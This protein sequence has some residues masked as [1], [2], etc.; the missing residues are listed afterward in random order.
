MAV[1]DVGALVTGGL[2]AGEMERGRGHHGHDASEAHGPCANCGTELIGPHCVEC[3]QPA[4]IHR[5]MMGLLHDIL[6]G[7]FH[8]EGKT[9]ATLPMLAL[10]P[11]HLTRRYIAGERVKFVSPMALFLFSVFLM[12]AIVS[13][14]TERAV[15]NMPERLEAGS[16]ALTKEEAKAITDLGKLKAERDATTDP[17][18]RRELET[19]IGEVGASLETMK[20]VQTGIAPARREAQARDRGEA[21]S[22]NTG[23]K[24]LDE[25][26]AHAGKNPQLVLYKVKTSAYKYSW[27]LI[28]ISLPFIWIMFFWKRGVGMY[29]HA[30]FATYSLAAMSLLVVVLVALS[31]VGVPKDALWVAFM[32]IP[33]IHMYKQLKYAYGLGRFGATWRTFMLLVSISF[34][35]TIFAA[36][37]FWMGMGH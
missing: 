35:T 8:F 10:R 25:S 16:H 22:I 31:F 7:V 26:L 15:E 29:D 17:T 19:R 13:G 32:V 5:N 3:G 1:D 37:L 9:W 27:A 30:I 24:W 21:V 4:H 36:L 20:K 12:F 14:I 23:W 34:T 28:P 18:Q 6:H 33:P 2:I 11:G